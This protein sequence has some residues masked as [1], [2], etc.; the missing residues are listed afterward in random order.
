ML[1]LSSVKY[2]EILWHIT[3]YTVIPYFYRSG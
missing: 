2:V 3:F 1:P